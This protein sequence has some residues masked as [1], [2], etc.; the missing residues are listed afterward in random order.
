MRGEGISLG[1]VEAIE[2]WVGVGRAET[3]ELNLLLWCPA[4]SSDPG[5]YTVAWLWL[6]LEYRRD[7]QLFYRAP[8]SSFS[9]KISN[10]CHSVFDSLENSSEK[11]PAPILQVSAWCCLPCCKA[12]YCPAV[13]LCFRR[14]LRRFTVGPAPTFPASS[15]APLTIK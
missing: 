14:L 9:K 6:Y 4:S 11:A 2:L 13:L 7:F 5:W 12:L 15:P 3:E 8:F 10:K 1:W